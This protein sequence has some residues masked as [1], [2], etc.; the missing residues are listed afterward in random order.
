MMARQP[1]KLAL[2]RGVHTLIYGVMASAT[3]ALLYIGVTG[4]F[5]AA[6]WVV[7]PLLAI[8]IAVFETCGLRCP[9]TAVVD[10]YAGASLHVSDTYF[11]E[12]LTRH[13]LSIFGPV[14]P[15]AFM[16]LAARS[17]GLIGMSHG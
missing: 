2:A 10:R 3:I 8:E 11:P 16:L 6:L 14:L 17:V 7:V 13:T 12:A 15:L 9:L 1:V 5:M 4:R